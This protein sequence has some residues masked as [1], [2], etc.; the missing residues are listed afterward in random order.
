M[1]RSQ[2]RWEAGTG[3]PRGLIWGQMLPQ[4]SAMCQASYY[5]PHGSSRPWSLQAGSY[6]WQHLGA[7]PL[8]AP[9]A[10]SFPIFKTEMT[11]ASQD[12]EILECVFQVAEHCLYL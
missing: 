4:A 10:L 3:S 5:R 7:Q 12:E 6:I 1:L 9:S 11:V 8:W 2:E